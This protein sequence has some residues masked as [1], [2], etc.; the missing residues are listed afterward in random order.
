VNLIALFKR[1]LSIWRTRWASIIMLAGRPVGQR[2][3]DGKP[4][5]LGVSAVDADELGQPSRAIS[6]SPVEL[7][8]PGF[9]LGQI[10]HVVD[11]VEQVL[12]RAVDGG[13]KLLLDGIGRVRA[14]AVRSSPECR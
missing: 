4:L 5:G 6:C 13:R 9:D 7:D 14:A 1:L 10:E 3:F 11:D 12:T 2:E 8:S